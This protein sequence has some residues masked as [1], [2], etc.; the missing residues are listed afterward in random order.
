MLRAYIHDKMPTRYYVDPK[1]CDFTNALQITKFA[2]IPIVHKILWYVD[3]TLR[4]YVRMTIS[5][6]ISLF[7]KAQ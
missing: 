3:C 4:T 1:T 6:I 5:L 7:H 2:K